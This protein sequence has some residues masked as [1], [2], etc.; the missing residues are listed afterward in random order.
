MSEAE[1]YFF[2]SYSHSDTDEYL[3]TFFDDLR[4]RVANISGEGPNADES[5]RE[6]ILNRIGFRD[7]EGIKNGQDW[8]RTIAKAIASSGVLV[9]LYTPT[10]FSQYKDYCGREFATFIMRDPCVRYA[11]WTDGVD[12]LFQLRGAR[13]IIPIIWWK[14]SH[15]ERRNLPPYVLRSISWTPDRNVLSRRVVERYI[16]DGMRRLLIDPDPSD[17]DDILDH[18]AAQID[19][20]TTR[21]LPI[22]PELPEFNEIRNAFWDK[23]ETSL[24]DNKLSTDAALMARAPGLSGPT[25][26]FIVEISTKLRMTSLW[27]PYRDAKSIAELVE[28]VANDKL[29]EMSRL[30]VDSNSPGFAN[31]V[32]AK[33]NTAVGE[34]ARAIL[35]VDP[36]IFESDIVRNALMALFKSPTRAGFVIPIDSDDNKARGIMETH[37]SLIKTI[38]TGNDWII[39]ISIGGQEDFKTA[40]SSVCDEILATL[41]RTS[42]VWQSPPDNGGPATQP[43]IS[44]SISMRTIRN[45]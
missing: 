11:R 41:V 16:R 27:C 3:D 2:F 30:E 40:I 10:Y 4:R 44:N 23:P 43:R 21:P 33:L 1:P 35:I 36:Y 14:L 9:C 24:I 45:V 37:S 38:G 18:F 12:E 25:R 17:Y 22:L 42:R 31:Q 28:E 32:V 15:L 29:L 8:T 39:R 5:S 7:F 26:M 13:N 6:D 34:G 19:E 20:L